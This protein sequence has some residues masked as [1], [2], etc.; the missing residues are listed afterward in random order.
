LT[1]GIGNIVEGSQRAI[2][3]EEELPK[4]IE[5]PDEPKREPKI[6][7]I[8]NRFNKNDRIILKNNKLTMPKDLTQINS[9]RL[10]EE[11]QKAANLAKSLGSKKR[12]AKSQ[13]DKKSYSME[14]ETLSKYRDT[15][16]NVISSRQYLP[17]EPAQSI[18]EL[19]KEID[20]LYEATKSEQDSIHRK[21]EM[22]IKY[23]KKD[24]MVVWSLIFQNYMGISKLWLIKTV[25]KYMTNKL[26]LTHLIF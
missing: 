26:T 1:E 2:T 9:E 5:G 15:I 6:L 18:S 10:S 7:D 21:R 23:H 24:S 25:R 14:F 11:R 17:K 3:F 16:N 13:D 19:E 20:E 12:H 22:P 4:A 8:D